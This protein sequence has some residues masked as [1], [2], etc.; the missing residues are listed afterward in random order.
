MNFIMDSALLTGG[1]C[2]TCAQVDA[3]REEAMRLLARHFCPDA[4]RM[5]ILVQGN[6][7]IM[8]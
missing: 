7:V 2:C 5:A 6:M 4:C 8:N 1:P 3:A